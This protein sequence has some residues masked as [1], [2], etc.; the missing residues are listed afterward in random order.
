MI[1]AITPV[2][3]LLIYFVSGR[4]KPSLLQLCIVCMICSGVII[5]SVGEL[6][7]SWTGFLLQMGAVCAECIRLFTMDALLKDT[8][9]DS[10]S[11]L[12]YTAPTSV[13]FLSVGF[14]V[15]ELPILPME[16]FTP[17]FCGI[18]LANGLLAFSL[19]VI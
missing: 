2:P 11:M 3:L 16:T 12:Y 5:S 7:F 10:L 14:L 17:Q 19:N 13:I 18:L 9:I 4:E 8:S 15:M 1:K 6:L